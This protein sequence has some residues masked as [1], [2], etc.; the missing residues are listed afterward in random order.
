MRGRETL[1]AAALLIDQHRSIGT[2][3][4]GAQSSHQLTNLIR[5]LNV[6]AE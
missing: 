3:H 1:D 5:R 6:T 2:I 4:D